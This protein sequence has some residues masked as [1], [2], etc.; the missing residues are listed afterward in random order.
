MRVALWGAAILVVL[1][2]CTKKAHQQK[3]ATEAQEDSLYKLITDLLEEEKKQS[4]DSL[5]LP[6]RAKVYQGS[7]PKRWQLVHTALSLSLDWKRQEIPGEAQ[8]TLHPYFAP[9]QELVLDAK[10]F[11]IEEVRLLRPQNGRVLSYRYDTLKLYITLDRFYTSRDTIT[12]YIRYVAQPEKIGEG[13]SM[14]I[15]GRK[16]GYFINADGKRPCIPRQFWTQGEP[17][18][19]SAWFPTIDAPNQKTTQQLCVTIEDSLVSLSNG[20]LVS[21]KKLPGGLRQ[22]CWELRQPHAPYLFA[23]VVGNFQV[24]KDAWRGK[25]VLYYME[26]SWVP[27]AKAIFGRTPQM[28]EF[29][30]NKTGVDFPW[31]KYG[32]VIV[33]DF[34]S[35]AMENTTAVI[36]GD[37][38]FYDKAKALTENHEEV[39]AHELFHHWFGD[40]VTCESWAQLPLNE[41]FADYSEYLW[42][43]HIE[44]VEAAENHRR[45]AFLSYT[46]EARDKKVPLI[47]FDY[48]DPM[49]M[50][51][52]HSYQ[53][54]G[55][56]LHLLR[57]LVG[58]SA[59]FLSI[60]QYLTENAYK[61]ADIDHLR[62]AFEKVTG[63][64]W[65]WFFDQHFHRADEVRLLV[66]GESRGDTLILSIRQ[67]DYDTLKGPYRYRF[68][69]AVLAA[70]GYEEIPIEF[71][72]DTILR[73]YRSGLRYADVDPKRLFIGR[74]TRDYPLRWWEAIVT[75]G[76]Y[77]WQR[78]EGLSQIQPYLSGDSEKLNLLFTAYRRGGVMWRRE[79]WESFQFIADTEAVAQILP[80]V[81]EGI[82]D[83][84]ARVRAAAW[85]FLVGAAQ[86]ELTSLAPWRDVLISALRDSSSEVQ[87]YALVALFQVDS[88]LAV[89][90]ARSRINSASEDIF[91]VSTILLTQAGD[92]QAIQ[93]LLNR[94][95]CLAGL[96]SRV[97][98]IS[99][100]V[101]A[102]QRAP[103]LRDKIFPLIQRIAREENPWYLR[104][105]MVQYLKFRLGREPEVARFL[106]QLKEEENHPQLRPIYQ[107][108]L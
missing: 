17:E 65:T 94:Y 43:E 7:Y 14:A 62:H 104:L 58:D 55:L 35:G 26:P 13:G 20:L 41:S 49:N 108:L 12:L 70:G 18:S 25:E 66:K 106:R 15:G 100:L 88:M 52:A 1:G 79:I 84:D 86:Q 46:A 34:V 99:L 53:K 5:A 22:D 73:L 76:R 21:Q 9:Q 103:N 19:A 105:Q 56:T 61:A 69:V 50:F 32:Q 85:A 57:N 93:N 23:L 28:L 4:S 33:R 98:A 2:A 45:Q 29:F 80:L 92:T 68:P 63:E 91:L 44:G 51:D 59:F 97:E 78:T 102:Y 90:E 11:R 24:I 60:R 95:P 74:S 72:K 10:A 39:V 75:D 64:D 36:H 81:R 89:K 82:N 48:G 96:S 47:R 101:L 67:R 37:M 87:N 83:P 31:P 77:F 27:H 42:L 6:H 16:G 71:E 3:I 107:R 40:L 30:S 38:L 8:L 54:G